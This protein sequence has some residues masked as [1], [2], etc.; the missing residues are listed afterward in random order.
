MNDQDKHNVAKTVGDFC[1]GLT[2][3][4]IG[5]AVFV[6][7][8]SVTVRNFQVEVWTVVSIMVGIALACFLARVTL[9]LSYYDGKPADIFK[10]WFWYLLLFVVMGVV[11]GMVPGLI[12]QAEYSKYSAECVTE[13]HPEINNNLQLF[14]N[15]TL[16]GLPVVTI[17][18]A[19]FIGWRRFR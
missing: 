7:V 4:S 5:W 3:F 13:Q 12:L 9:F 1:G 18:Y 2:C 15:V 14:W 17:M 6:L 8:I 19:V 16:M 10:H 11:L